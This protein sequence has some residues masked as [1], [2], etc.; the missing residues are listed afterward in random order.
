M[1]DDGNFL[2][3]VAVA[4]DADGQNR[5]DD[6]FIID[7]ASHTHGI[8]A[9][10]IPVAASAGRLDDIAPRQKYA[11]PRNGTERSL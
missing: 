7:L 5:R 4:E 6:I 3:V 11:A 2:K 8:R 10:S 9:C 1:A